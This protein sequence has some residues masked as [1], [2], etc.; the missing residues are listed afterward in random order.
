MKNST[1]NSPFQNLRLQMPVCKEWAYFDHAA[2]APLPTP[3]AEEISLWAKEMSHQ[4][5][6]C[7][8]KWRQKIE[9]TRKLGAHLL[10]ALEEEICL[11][12]NTTEGIAIVA[13]S[14]P[15]SEGEN[16]VVLESEFP[17]NCFPW[18][19][20]KHRGVETRFCSTNMESFAPEQLFELIDSK[21]RIVS[22]SWVGYRTGF[23]CDLHQLA[24]GIHQRGALL[25][26]DG[27]QGL[28]VFDLNTTDVP[29]DFLAADG[30]KWLLGPEGAGFLFIRS[31]LRNLLLSRGI[32]WNSVVNAGA[33]HDP[34]LILKESASR[35]EGGTYH[36][37]GIAG[38]QASLKM[39]QS[40]SLQQRELRVRYV[41]DQ[42]VEGLQRLGF[43]IVSDRSNDHWSGIVSCTRPE[44]RLHYL[45]RTCQQQGVVVNHRGGYLRLS[46]HLYNNQDD[47]ERLLD[48]LRESVSADS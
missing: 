48:V 2:V 31:H 3:C 27:I 21:T 38:L 42:L 44:I 43:Q 10:N 28:G 1:A 14:F 23:R 7:W 24:E 5:T 34:Q 9:E 25:F 22:V 11:I 16:V 13:E 40:I 36:V 37:A 17:S 26:V 12:R 33:F 19:T 20:L 47:I 41:T 39:L 6:V 4:G 15:W 8:A 18:M 29:I 35:Y 32:G 30:H 46:P 45:K